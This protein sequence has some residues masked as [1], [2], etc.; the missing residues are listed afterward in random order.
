MLWT[1]SGRLRG[2]K[3]I[4]SA[5]SKECLLESKRPSKAIL[6]SAISFCF[7]VSTYSCW[8]RPGDEYWQWRCFFPGSKNSVP[9]LVP[10]YCGIWMRTLTA[11]TWPAVVLV[12]PL[13]VLVAPH[14]RALSC[15][16]RQLPCNCPTVAC[17]IGESWK[18]SWSGPSS[19]ALGLI[20][21]SS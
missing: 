9:K 2:K 19:C 14:L 10:V 17:E 3:Q 21:W 18:F 16:T 20:S 13:L 11:T 6:Q 15:Q 5:I 12:A 4:E 1:T 7:Q 8:S